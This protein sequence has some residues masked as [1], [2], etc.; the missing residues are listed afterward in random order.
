MRSV[1]P[2]RWPTAGLAVLLA[3]AATA[4]A[5]EP[6]L[7][8]RIDALIDAAAVGPLAPPASAMPISSAG[9]IST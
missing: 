9:S 2:R 6:P 3:L 4:V 7:H 5:D 1:F 8:E